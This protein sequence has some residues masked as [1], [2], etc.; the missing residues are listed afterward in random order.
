MELLLERLRTGIS[1]E[2]FC[3]SPRSFFVYTASGMPAP[4]WMEITFMA[5]SAD[6][7]EYRLLY[8]L[9]QVSINCYNN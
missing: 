1:K 6:L 9:Y 2:R 7:G 3:I 8:L 4:N 5:C